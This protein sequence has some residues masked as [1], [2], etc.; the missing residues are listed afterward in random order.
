MLVWDEQGSGPTIVLAHGFAQTRRCWAGLDGRLAADHRV[1][2]VDLPGHGDSA[3]VVGSVVEGAMLLVDAGGVGA[4]IGYSLG[5]RHVLAAA[6]A[7]SDLVT[8]MVLIGGT[9]GIADD[10][11][12][13]NRRRLDAERALLVERHGA[14]EFVRRWVADPPYVRSAAS[15]PDLPERLRNTTAGLAGSLRLAGTGSMEPLW[16]SLPAVTAPTLLVVG[17]ADRPYREVA[18]RMAA[19]MPSAEVA[20]IPGAG[21]P[22]HT[23]Q[24]GSTASAIT[25]FLRSR[26]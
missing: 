11:E 1:V 12:R 22:A 25:R 18:E 7:R 4:Y 3:A 2:R 24:P 23:D 16:D 14:P 19:V 9:A 13:E 21:H 20:V 6:V 17:D 10:G 26:H 5:A 15:D 8:A